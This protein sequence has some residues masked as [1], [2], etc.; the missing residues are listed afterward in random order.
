MFFRV[1]VCEDNKFFREK[2]KQIIEDYS[3]MNNLRIE[4]QV[5][6]TG[7]ELLDDYNKKFFNILFLDIDMGE[8]LSGIQIAK[9]VRE[10]DQDVVIIFATAFEEFALDAFQVSAMQYLLKPIKVG[11]VTEL[12]DKA[13][14]QIE[15]NAAQNLREKQSIMI[16]TVDG[17]QNLLIDDIIYIHKHRNH[18]IYHTELEEYYCYDT[19]KE[20]RKR[21]NP[22]EFVQVN[23]GEIVNWSKVVSAGRDKVVLEDMEFSVSRKYQQEVKDRYAKDIMMKARDIFWEK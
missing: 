14:R 2:L 4:V 19:M 23:Q 13:L 11:Q 12:L 10:L 7:E 5:Y 9:K 18:V 1:A 21:L 22:V 17:I 3:K 20:L 6:G 15:V 8:N 16:E